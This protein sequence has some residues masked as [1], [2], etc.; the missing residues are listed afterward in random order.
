MSMKRWLTS[1][2][3]AGCFLPALV[4]AQ[5]KTVTKEGPN[6][7]SFEKAKTRND[8]GTISTEKT[9][10]GPGG[11]SATSTRVRD[12]DGSDGERGQTITQTGPNGKTRTA[13]QTWTKNEDGTRTRERS[14]TGGA[15]NT[16]SST[17]N[18]GNG[19]ASKTIVNRKGGTRTVTRP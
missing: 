2:V 5:T 8:N 15:G 13:S 19:Q 6:G 11:K 14:A 16:R 1:V 18:V 3:V 10:T 4:P 9:I 17:L 12:R 7:A